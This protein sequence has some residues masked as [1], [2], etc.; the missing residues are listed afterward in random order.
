MI[1][2]SRM[3]DSVSVSVYESRQVENDSQDTAVISWFSPRVSQLV[4]MYRAFFDLPRDA[5]E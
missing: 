1:L 5:M 3:I 4:A 2:S